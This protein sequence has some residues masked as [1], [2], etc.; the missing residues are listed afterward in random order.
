MKALKALSLLCLMALTACSSAYY[1]TM[2]R[3]GVPKRDILVSRIG[4]A[5][6]AQEEGQ[7]QFKDALEQFRSVVEFDGG[8]LQ[9]V[10]NRLETEF[11]NSERAATRIRD[12]IAAVED[13]AEALFDEWQ[14][15]L[16]LYSNPEL[17]SDSERQLQATRDRY[18]RL[19]QAMNRAESTLD[20][21]LDNLRDN[22]LYLKH[23]LNAR[24]ISSLRGELDT[25]NTDVDNLIN[26]MQA[27]I[28]ESDRFIADMQS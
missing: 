3:L 10:Y 15:E 5:Q 23:N 16:E 4:E 13:V 19:M 24:A 26:A 11:E 25:I 2:E 9:Q 21:V 14:D 20:P 22:V 8:E 17:R 6:T 18:G 27:A 28:A 1:G 7:Q 12:R